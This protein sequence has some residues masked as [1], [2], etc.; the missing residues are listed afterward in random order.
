MYVC[1]GWYLRSLI[2]RSYIL[3]AFEV[4]YSVDAVLYVFTNVIRAFN[5]CLYK[6]IK[7]VNN[8]TVPPIGI[9]NPFLCKFY[10][11]KTFIDNNTD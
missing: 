11:W 3:H 1:I 2:E 8:K 5:N 9:S 6:D 10:F 7:L 4:Q